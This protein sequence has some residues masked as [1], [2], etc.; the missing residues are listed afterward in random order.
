MLAAIVL[1]SGCDDT[2]TLEPPPPCVVGTLPGLGVGPDDD[3][4]GLRDDVDRCPA[5]PVDCGDT[6]EDG[7]G[8]GCDPNALVAGDVRQSFDSF[9]EV[10]DRW[11]ATGA[12]RW[13][14]RDSAF[15][16]L[17]IADGT[18][19]RPVEL[20]VQ[21]TID[22]VVDVVFGGEG[23]SV[24]VWV[25]STNDI[26]LECRV[27]HH[28]RGDELVMLLPTLGHTIDRVAMS[29]D[30]SG[31]LRI[32]G[33]QLPDNTI[34]CRARY[35]SSHEVH[36]E[37]SSFQVPRDTFDTLGFRTVQAAA[38]I[39]SAAIYHVPSSAVGAG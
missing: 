31:G 4:D 18:V 6:D 11:I 15:R 28:A 8:D 33:G 30:R 35:G 37:W 29:G 5:D 1:A 27:V 26:P 12:A 32:H 25:A 20:A 23:A 10:D 36:V 34:R 2:L 9:D 22:V 38:V 3:G 17:E 21:P 19:Q 39:R 24:G 16:Q 13:E 7:V 14:I